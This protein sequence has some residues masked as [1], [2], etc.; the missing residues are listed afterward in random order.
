M[1][2]VQNIIYPAV[3][4]LVPES[5]KKKHAATPRKGDKGGIGKA[6]HA[7]RTATCLQVTPLKKFKAMVM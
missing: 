7:S 5:L 4:G 6:K 3:W 1:S 2:L